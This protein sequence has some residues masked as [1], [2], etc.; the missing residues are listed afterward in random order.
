MNVL[1]K[2]LA[3]SMIIGGVFM[4]AQV[5]RKPQHLKQWVTINL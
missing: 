2:G 4:A 1:A 3:A 5:T